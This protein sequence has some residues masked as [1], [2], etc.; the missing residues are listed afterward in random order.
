MRGLNLR[1]RREI[2]KIS[3]EL[4]LLSPLIWST[5]WKHSGIRM[6]VGN[7]SVTEHQA[8]KTVHMDTKLC[9][10]GGEVSD[11]D[12]YQRAGPRSAIGRALD[13]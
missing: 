6:A 3:F 10:H 7:C 5:G 9:T 2:R 12:L 8:R 1:F 13:S 4:S 11:M